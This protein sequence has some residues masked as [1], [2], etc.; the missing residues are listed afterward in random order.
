MRPPH[1]PAPP[2][3]GRSRSARE[4]CPGAQRRHHVLEVIQVAEGVLGRGAPSV[5]EKRVRLWGVALEGVR[6]KVIR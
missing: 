2:P 5:E 4:G 1:H 6:H 3:R